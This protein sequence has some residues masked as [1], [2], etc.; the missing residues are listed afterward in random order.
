MPTPWPNAH[1]S[2][3]WV[4]DDDILECAYCL[5]RIY[6][7]GAKDQCPDNPPTKETET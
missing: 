1:D 5:I 6:N 2:H 4:R 3:R 7:D